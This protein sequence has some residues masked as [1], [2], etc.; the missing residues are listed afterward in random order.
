MIGSAAIYGSILVI[1]GVCFNKQWTV[2]IISLC[3]CTL[4]SDWQ[5]SLFMAAS[6]WYRVST[7]TSKGLCSIFYICTLC[8]DQQCSHLWQCPGDAR[9]LL[10]QTVD[11]TDNPYVSVHF[12]GIGNAAVYGNV[13]VI[14]GVYFNK[15]RSLANGVALA[16][17][18]IGQFV[19]P[20]FIEFLLETYGLQGCLLLVSMTVRGCLLLVSMTLWEDA[21]S[22]LVW[23]CERMPPLG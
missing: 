9:C 21:S 18:S 23:L 10:Q 20:P 14:L 12:A 19:L 2:V 13:L 22:W 5:C 6:W 11:H 3:I 1:P 17:A 7:S 4:C 16:G 15:R 8:K